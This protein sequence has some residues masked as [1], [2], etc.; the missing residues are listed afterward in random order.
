[1]DVPLLQQHPLWPSLR[2]VQTGRVYAI[3]G[4]QYLNRS[5]PRL[6]ESAELLAQALWGEQ[7]GV[8]VDSPGWKHI[9]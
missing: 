8:K 1:I 3:D 5:G 4:N 9:E 6:V 2:A 7:A